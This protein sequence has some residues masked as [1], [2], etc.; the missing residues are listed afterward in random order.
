MTQAERIA[1][2]RKRNKQARNTDSARW[3]RDRHVSVD[4]RGVG[5]NTDIRFDMSK[6]RTNAK[7]ANTKYLNARLGKAGR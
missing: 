6:V 5:Y 7:D 2:Q 3:L 1:H 4:E